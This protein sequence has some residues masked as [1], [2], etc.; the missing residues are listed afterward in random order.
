MGRRLNRGLLQLGSRM[1]RL[2]RDM[3]IRSFLKPAKEVP[4]TW[5]SST[6]PMDTRPRISTLTILCIGLWI[7]GTGDAILIARNREYPLDGS[8]RRY[9]ENDGR[10]NRSGH[11][12]CQ[13][14]RPIPLDSTQG[15]TRSRHNT[16]CNPY[17]AR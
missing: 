15:E 5:W 4:T 12:A 13:L 16:Q 7:F 9:C 17:C 1:K 3:V 11:T 2:S 10:L 8:R 14:R 6:N